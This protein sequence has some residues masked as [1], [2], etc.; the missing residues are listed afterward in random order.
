MYKRTRQEPMEVNLLDFQTARRRLKPGEDSW[1][2]G[3]AVKGDQQ[4]TAMKAPVEQP[5]T[6]RKPQAERLPVA[7]EGERRPGLE[8]PPPAQT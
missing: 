3:A 2:A 4:A 7:A 6:G 1:R 5:Q 8:G